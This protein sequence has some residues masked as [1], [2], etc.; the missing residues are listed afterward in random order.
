MDAVTIMVVLFG[1]MAL[2]GLIIGLMFLRH[3]LKK[4]E[5]AYTMETIKTTVIPELEA[6]T[7]RMLENSMDMVV[8]KSVEVA[9]K[10]TEAQFD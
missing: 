6:M 9:K 8:N 3:A 4:R 2:A 1:L 7:S 5:T 10:M